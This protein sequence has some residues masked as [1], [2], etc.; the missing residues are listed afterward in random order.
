MNT[1][2]YNSKQVFWQRQT[3]ASGSDS[4]ASVSNRPL[5]F[6]HTVRG[7][8]TRAWLLGGWQQAT[9]LRH[10]APFPPMWTW[11]GA[12]N[13]NTG[14]LSGLQRAPPP[15]GLDEE[16]EAMFCS[17][18]RCCFPKQAQ[19]EVSSHTGTIIFFLCLVMHVILCTGTGLEVTRF[20]VKSRED[21]TNCT[22][23]W[24]LEEPPQQRGR[25]WTWDINLEEQLRGELLFFW[26]FPRGPLLADIN[27]HTHTHLGDAVMLLA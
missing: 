22:P 8:K 15:P 20:T 9:F 3:R 2:L 18:L 14:Y 19:G 25:E 26:S 17:T 21:L 4:A 1:C 12:E 16:N 6:W 10:E 5:S 27:T 11:L 23:K 13:A 24:P 7:C